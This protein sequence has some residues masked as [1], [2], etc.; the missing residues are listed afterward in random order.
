MA[1]ETPQDGGQ[2]PPSDPTHIEA[3]Q[4]E[5]LRVAQVAT[6]EQYARQCLAVFAPEPQDG[7]LSYRAIL[8][9]LQTVIT[10]ALEE[11]ESHA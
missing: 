3:L 9:R 6:R 2:A 11:Q 5:R 1:E 7:T 8:Q 10:Q 4:A